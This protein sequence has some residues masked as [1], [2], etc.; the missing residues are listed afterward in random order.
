M[1]QAEELAEAAGALDAEV[2]TAEYVSEVYYSLHATHWLML[3]PNL[4]YIYRPGGVI[5]RTDDIVLGLKAIV[6]L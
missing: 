2:Q 4:Q 1:T 3:R 5:G 6:T